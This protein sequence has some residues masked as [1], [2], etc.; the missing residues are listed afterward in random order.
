MRLLLDH[1]SADA[2]TMMAVANGYSPLVAAAEFAVHN[3]GYCDLSFAPLLFLL[4]RVTAD[5]PSDDA[6]QKHMTKVM[7]AL[8]QD[9]VVEH[10]DDGEGQWEERLNLFEVDQP[11]DARDD[12]VRLL[13]PAAGVWIWRR[14]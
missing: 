12:C 8:C 5:A 1:P 9:R 4:R 11:D 7:E 2:A 3:A 14:L 13:T 6:H 10:W